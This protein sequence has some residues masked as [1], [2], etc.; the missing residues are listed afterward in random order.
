MARGSEMGSL[1]LQVRPVKFATKGDGNLVN[2]L[3]I[4]LIVT[5]RCFRGKENMVVF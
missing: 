5:A 2:F 1:P 3:L 4:N